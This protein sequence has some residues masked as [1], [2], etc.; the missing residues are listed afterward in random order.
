MIG[1]D[2]APPYWA[3]AVIHSD[4][5]GTKKAIDDTIFE[6]GANNIQSSHRDF[7][8]F[9]IAYDVSAID[10]PLT[11]EQLDMLNQ[12]ASEISG[13]STAI[14]TIRQFHV[15]SDRIRRS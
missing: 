2:A 3:L 4:A 5:R 1:V 11:P 14:R 13:D 6:A 12:R 15:T 7:R 8:Q 10:K 9:G